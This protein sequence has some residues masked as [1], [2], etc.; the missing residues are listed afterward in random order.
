MKLQAKHSSLFICGLFNDAVSSS[1]T[2]ASG[3]KVIMND[4]LE[5]TGKEVVVA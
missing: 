4:E 5:R 1:D 2:V 3:D